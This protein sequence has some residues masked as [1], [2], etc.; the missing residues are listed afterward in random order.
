[1]NERLI[2]SPVTFIS[3]DDSSVVSNPG[4][5]PLDL[6]PTLI[7][8]QLSAVLG[9]SFLAVLSMRTN[10]LNSVLRKSC[11]KWVR[12]GST[13]VDQSF[14]PPLRV[15]GGLVE[16]RF[17]EFDFARG[18]RGELNSQRNTLA[19][20]HHHKLRTLSTLG[21]SDSVPPFFAG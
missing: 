16:G 2:Y 21:F 18:R 10:Q 20:C 13:V 3:H 17:D 14:D 19:V 1:M 12:I 8:S 5:R 4:D 9:F 7:S 6:P 11:S 15:D